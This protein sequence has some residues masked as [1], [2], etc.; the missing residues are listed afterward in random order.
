MAKL[1]GYYKN[2]NGEKCIPN[3]AYSIFIDSYEKV[4]ANVDGNFS[5]YT[6]NSKFTADNTIVLN[7]YNTMSWNGYSRP[8]I[9]NSM[10][11][12]HNETSTGVV[13]PVS[14]MDFIVVYI[15]LK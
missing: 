1:K 9:H 8:Y 11:Y 4:T 15:K 5:L 2:K 10:W 6:L 7:V 12:V 14:N 3:I 13:T